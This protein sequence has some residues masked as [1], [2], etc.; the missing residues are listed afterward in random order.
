MKAMLER[1][2]LFTATEVPR[3]NLSRQAEFW[4]GC[5]RDANTGAY[6]RAAVEILDGNIDVFALERVHVG[7][8]PKWN[9]D[10]MTGNV[11]PLVF[12]KKLDYRDSALVGDIKYLWEPNRHLHLVMLAQAYHLTAERRYLDGLVAELNSWFEQCPYLLGPNWTSSLEVSIRLIN[13]S[14][15]W[16]LVGG[17]DSPM[18]EGSK[19]TIFLRRWLE[20]IYQHAHFIRGHFSRFSSANNHL[21]GE[22]AGLF[23]TAITWPY[24]KTFIVWRRTA[25]QILESE[26]LLQNAP[27]GVNREQTVWY[28]QFVLDFLI[29]AG[30]AG[31]ANSANFSEAYWDRIETMLEFLAS[32]MDVAGN[33]PM[34]GDADDGFVVRL[35][36]EK[37]WCPYKSLLATGA[38]LF[39]RG[40]FKIK[41][42]AL[43]HKTQWLLV[44][45]TVE[46]YGEIEEDRVTLPIRRAFSQ[47]GYYILG[48]NFETE[49]EIRLIVDAGSLGY[50]SIAAHGHAD[51]LAFTLSIAGREFLIDPGTY[52]YHTQELWRNYFRGT[53]AHNTIRVDGQNQSVIGGKFMWMQKANAECQLWEPGGKI[54]HFVGVHDGYQRLQDPVI[55]RREIRVLKPERKIV[56]KDILECLGPHLVQCYWHFSEGCNVVLEGAGLIATNAGA[57]IKLLTADPE[58]KFEIARGKADPPTGWVSRRFGVKVPTTTAVGSIRIH[59][60]HTLCTEILCG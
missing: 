14:I 24:W 39:D 36:M 32:V 44:E 15:I 20:S 19:G 51:A 57:S 23:V 3:P 12:G 55:H 29:I 34:I 18:F 11:A 6:C 9:R 10:P 31:R 35:S 53:S 17:K 8:P 50:Q 5:P 1:N 52:T 38:V 40:D 60:T 28:Q 4:L 37:G 7:H 16:Q 59:G 33:V 25:Q 49:D 13:W 27:D 47:G 56:V 41:A 2:G 45:P 46:R 58:I 54:D 42:G 48:N 21:I 30:L 22:A 43:D 26:T